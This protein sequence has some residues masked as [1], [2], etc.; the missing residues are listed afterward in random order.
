V[1]VVNTL[2]KQYLD[3]YLEIRRLPGVTAFFTTQLNVYE[4]K[5]RESEE[6]LR[7]FEGRTA[8]I[9]TATQLEVFSRQLAEAEQT[10]MKVRYDILD[11]R[12]KLA[13]S[14]AHLV[15]LPERLVVSQQTRYNPLID[16]LQMRL[17]DLEVEREKL[18]QSYTDQDRRVRD[19]EDRIAMLAQRLSEQ[20]EWVP[21]NETSQIHPLRQHLQESMLGTETSL[22]R[23]KIDQEEAAEAVI[24]LKDR[25]GHIAK[26]AVDRAE[27]NREVKA[28]EEAYLLYRRKVEEARISE[29]MDEQKIVNVSIAE[30]ATPPMAPITSKNLSYAFALMVGLVAGVGGGFLR[31]FIDDSIKSAADVTSSTALPVLASIP[32]DKPHGKKN[33]G[34][35]GMS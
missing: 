20:R 25:I 34:Q 7:Q 13:S 15:S 3:R 6:A 35:A 32:E 14:K 1:D 16:T 19:V 28:N 8:L 29:A 18:L 17:L 31:E 11:K 9:N 27:L 24:R 33:G 10:L 23:L 21:G 5:L 30:E 2:L 22:D 4:Q 12:Q 26:Q